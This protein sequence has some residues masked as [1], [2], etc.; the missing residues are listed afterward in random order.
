M[1][2]LYSKSAGG[3]F[4]D[5]I[6]TLEQI[7]NDAV[8]ISDATYDQLFTDQKAGLQIVGDASGDPVSQSYDP[9]Y[10]LTAGEAVPKK[11]AKFINEFTDDNINDEPT[12]ADLDLM[13]V[14]QLKRIRRHQITARYNHAMN[15]ILNAY[16]QSEIDSWSE[17]QR[18]ADAW[19]AERAANPTMTDAEARANTSAPMLKE[20]A[21]GK[22]NKTDETLTVQDMDDYKDSII[23]K[24][25]FF[26]PYSGGLVGIKKRLLQVIDDQLDDFSGEPDPAAA[27]QA[28]KDVLKALD[29]S[30]I[31]AA[32][33]AY[34][35]ENT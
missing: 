1:G 10:G 33:Y 2:K 21:K 16:Q 3:F 26:R 15:W 7:P 8:A 29:S 13:E 6:H 24:S 31:L 9:F 17:Q 11:V 18:D 22:A 32:G 27:E 5:E 23:S 25:G 19:I 12:Q 30:E 34:I 35:L 20:L 4:D 28:A 14:D